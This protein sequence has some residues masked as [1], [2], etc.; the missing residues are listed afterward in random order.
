MPAGIYTAGMSQTCW[1]TG[2]FHHATGTWEMRRPGLARL[3]SFIRKKKELRSSVRTVLVGD[4][5]KFVQDICP[6]GGFFL[7]L[8][9]AQEEKNYS[10]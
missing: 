9:L 10:K 8:T 3:L 7:Y 4:G 5:F 2:L 1:N 6:T